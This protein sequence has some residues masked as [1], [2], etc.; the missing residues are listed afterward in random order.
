VLFSVS[1]CGVRQGLRTIPYLT[2]GRSGRAA[3][4]SPSPCGPAQPVA[5]RSL[6]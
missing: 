5:C 6:S 1:P 3:V 2:S 4:A